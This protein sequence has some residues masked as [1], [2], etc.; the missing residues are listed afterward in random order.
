MIYLLLFLQ[1]LNVGLFTFG[2]GYGA[3]PLI[4]ETVT[5]CGWM[6]EDELTAILGVSESTP[7][8]IMVNTATYVGNV[9]G[10][11]AGGVWGGLLG[12]M[13]ATLG[14]VL[15]SFVIIL[16][17]AM[18][19]RRF[20]EKKPVRAVLD[21]VKPCI[22][23]V[24]FVVAVHMFVDSLVPVALPDFSLSVLEW[25]AVALILII[26]ALRSGWKMWKGKPVPPVLTIAVAAVL[27][28]LV[29]GV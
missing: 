26:G 9:M 7:G 4:Q 22:V 3:I 18:V 19:F 27:G 6:T 14:V 2:G 20:V 25:R 21:G 17:I 24:I 12:A 10:S 11:E 16:L 8:P 5:G 29:Y 28:V 23:G 1:F 13:C 15:P